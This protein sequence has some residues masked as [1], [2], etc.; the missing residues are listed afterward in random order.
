MILDFTLI[1]QMYQTSRFHKTSYYFKITNLI[2]DKINLQFMK[3]NQIRYLL[4]VK[5]Q[6]IYIGWSTR[7]RRD[8]FL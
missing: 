2:Q 7:M 5:L 6:V 4:L 1:L 8:L 3:Q